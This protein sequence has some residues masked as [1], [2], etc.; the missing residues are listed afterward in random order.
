MVGD[1]NQTRDFTYV[2][3]VVDAMIKAS[4]SKAKNRIYNV[5]SGKTISVNKIVELLGEKNLHS[6]KTRRTRLYFCLILIK[7][8]KI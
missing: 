3:D 6:K 8:K 7:S 1:G 2:T 4:R 5:G